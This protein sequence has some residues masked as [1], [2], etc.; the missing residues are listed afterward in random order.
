MSILDYIEKIKE[1][2]EG[3]DPRSMAQEPRNMAHGGR[4]GFAENAGLV[5]ANIIRREESINSYYKKYGK[6][7]LDK[8]AKRDYGKIFSKLEQNDISNFKRRVDKW[9]IKNYPI[10]EEARKFSAQKRVL[11]DQG[12]Q[13]KLLEETNKKKFFDAKKF[14]KANKITMKELK[15]Q[16]KLLRNNI[17]DK[18]MLVSGKDMGGATLT[19][20]PD[21]L[22]AADNALDKMWKS[23]LIV[24]D[25][26]VID[27]LFYDAFGKP[28]SPTYNAKKFLAIKDNLNEYRQ[29]KN[30]IKAKYPHINLQLDHP[31]SKSILN[32]IF[33]ASA[34]E[35]T[36]VNI[37]D[38]HLNNSFKDSLSRKYQQSLGYNVKGEKVGKVNLE[39]KKAVEKVARDLK[40]N[41]GK[42]STD[43]KDFKYGVKEFQKLNIRDEIIKS[44][45]N[46]KDLSLNFKSYIKNNPDLLTIAG[47]DDLS[48]IGTKLT[49]ITDKQIQGVEKLIEKIGCP[50]LAS[51]GRASFLDGTTCFKKGQA[52]INSGMKGATKAQA[53]NFAKF[54]NNVYRGARWVTKWGIIPEMLF[55]G[56]ETLVHM[57]MGATMDEGFKK[58]V[59]YIPGLKETGKEGIESTLSRMVGSDN[60]KI[61]MNVNNMKEEQAKLDSLEQAKAAD[62]A[63]NNPGFTGM[64]DE[65]LTNSYNKQIAKQ[66]EILKSKSVSD[67]AVAYGERMEEEATDIRKAKNPWFQKFIQKAR[68][69]EIEDPSGETWT[70][71][72]KIDFDMHPS[73]L[74]QHKDFGWE[75]KED[76]EQYK[77]YS[78]KDIRSL[79]ESGD[80]SQEDIE[81]ILKMQKIAKDL[82]P[83]NFSLSELA[84]MYGK[85]Q[86]YG[87]QGHMG[88]PLAGGGMVGIRKPSAIAPTGGP[89]SQGLRS[90]YI[91][92]KDY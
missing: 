50:G 33:N 35:L 40:L 21:D 32:K 59:S 71:P 12:I 15:Y 11:K 58:S 90:L 2:Y 66:N 64:T 42:V 83:K 28:D 5:G 38:A 74:N 14:A 52:L 4:I 49:K 39:A 18:R 9:G 3:E 60:A 56:G 84:S 45:K 72:V 1:M 47:Y 7:E 87:T 77:K 44:L 26:N 69:I 24:N 57:G 36:R 82:D 85:E 89:M 62:L 22:K 75:N 13:I 54:A 92:D 30:A 73:L 81:G 31:L 6:K 10:E 8:L 51:G 53:M 70:S 34:E 76:F 88:Q 16:A 91:N 63:V 78:E 68:D 29:L 79:A 48:K 25:R 86:V 80:F 23:E 19:W 65:D 37:L 41:I 55:I 20:I 67:A 61:I 27:N 43:L 46:Q 17:Y